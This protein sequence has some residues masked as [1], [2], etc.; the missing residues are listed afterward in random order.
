MTCIANSTQYCGGNDRLSLYT[1]SVEDNGQEP[2]TTVIATTQSSSS[3]FITSVPSM[4]YVWINATTIIIHPSATNVSS[5]TSVL[6]SSSLS[7]AST[8]CSHWTTK[9]VTRSSN[10]M[11]TTKRSSEGSSPRTTS[12][13]TTH[14]STH[15]KPTTLTRSISSAGSANLTSSQMTSMVSKCCIATDS[16]SKIPNSDPAMASASKTGSAG[17]PIPSDTP[18]RVG[19]DAG[20]AIGTIASVGLLAAAVYLISRYIKNIRGQ[21]GD[22]DDSAWWEHE[23]DQAR[24]S[25]MSGG[26]TGGIRLIRN[27]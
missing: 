19:Q 7:T 16:S 14:G 12:A 26:L 3:Q 25:A 27:S 10:A 22:K 4:T 8:I 21:A 20:I 2:S 17:N 23:A 5:T 1:W 9:A 24:S 13:L 11:T 6:E 15:T 18:S